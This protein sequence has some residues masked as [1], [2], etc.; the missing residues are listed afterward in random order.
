M[1]K[2]G[3][4]RWQSIERVVHATGIAYIAILDDLAYHASQTSKNSSTAKGLHNTLN[5]IHTIK[6]A[7]TLFLLSDVLPHVALLSQRF[8]KETVSWYQIAGAVESKQDVL[9]VFKVSNGLYTE[10]LIKEQ[11]Q[12]DLLSLHTSSTDASHC[13]DYMETIME[14]TL[15]NMYFFYEFSPQCKGSLLEFQSILGVPWPIR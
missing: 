10:S 5:T 13:V 8:Q 2:S 3:H 1:C 11:P 14:P 6:F 15:N 4:T 7:S 12:P 9:H